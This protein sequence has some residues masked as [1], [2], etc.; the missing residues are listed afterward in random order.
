MRSNLKA[1]L[2]ERALSIRKVAADIGYNFEGV[3]RMYNDEM[4][5][6]PRDLLEKLCD[7]LGVEIDRLLVRD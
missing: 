7:Y 5:R 1:I 3:R 4:D 2:D 6:Y